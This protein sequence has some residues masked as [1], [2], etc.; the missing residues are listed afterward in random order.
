MI[1]K[2]LFYEEIVKEQFK[3]TSKNCPRPESFEIMI[4]NSKKKLPRSAGGRGL[5]VM[6]AR[7][8]SF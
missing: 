6:V 5:Y 2:Q 7:T 8:L 3:Y 4:K 1:F